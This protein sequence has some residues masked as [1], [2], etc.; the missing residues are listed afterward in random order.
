MCFLPRIKKRIGGKHQFCIILTK[1]KSG[2]SVVAI[3]NSFI[4]L[5]IAGFI[6]FDAR[7]TKEIPSSPRLIASDAAKSRFCFSLKWGK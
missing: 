5:H 7:E 2:L 6:K 3:V 4:H 1:S